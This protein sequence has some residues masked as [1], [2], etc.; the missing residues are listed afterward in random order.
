MN[1]VDQIM[2]D[3]T[4][5]VERKDYEQYITSR[6]PDRKMVIVTCMDTRLTEMLPKAMNLRNGDAKIIKNAGGIVTQPFGNIMRSV[7]I[8]IYEL[9]AD[10]VFVIGHHGC[11]MT[12]LNPEVI[13]QH[14]TDR[15]VPEQTVE[16]LRHSGLNFMRW[17]TGFDNV[18]ES[19]EK[20][21]G[22]IRN[23]PLLPPN[24]PV[25]GMTIEPETGQ[26]DLIVNGYDK[27]KQP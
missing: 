21:V 26:L 15:G 22:I 2:N 12:G 11:G 19:V 27:L 18:K 6:F 9:Q 17:L 3:N 25:H 10:E 7:L 8:A 4:A 24:V 23:H 20:S 14:M 16:T 1:N 5:F 13:V